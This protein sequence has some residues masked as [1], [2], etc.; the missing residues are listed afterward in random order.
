MQL[1][2]LVAEAARKCLESPTCKKYTTAVLAKVA[3]HRSDLIYGNYRI[4]PGS[5]WE[6]FVGFRDLIG[7]VLAK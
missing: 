1:Y 3:L 7:F 2:A 5:N 6:S 4:C